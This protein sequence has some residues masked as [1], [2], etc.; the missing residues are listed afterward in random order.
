MGNRSGQRVGVQASLRLSLI[1]DMFFQ[2]VTG[3]GMMLQKEPSGD[4]E[5]G[6]QNVWY[7][8]R[9]RMND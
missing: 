2:R 3:Q 9:P 8:H 4:S 1:G 7:G 5:V 6:R